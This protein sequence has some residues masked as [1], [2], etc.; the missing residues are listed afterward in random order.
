MNTTKDE[1]SLKQKLI[2]NQSIGQPVAFYSICHF[3]LY[4]FLD[5]AEALLV[6]LVEKSQM[7]KYCKKD[8]VDTPEQVKK[9]GGPSNLPHQKP[10]EQNAL[11]TPRQDAVPQKD[12][13][14]TK[15]KDGQTTGGH[16]SEQETSK[17]THPKKKIVEVEK[18]EIDI[19]KRH[20]SAEKK[21]QSSQKKDKNDLQLK[22]SSQTG[23]KSNQPQKKD[24][25]MTKQEQSSKKVSSIKKKTPSKKEESAK[26]SKQSGKAAVVTPKKNVPPLQ[27]KSDK[28]S[29]TAPKPATDGSK[30]M[31]FRMFNSSINLCDVTHWWI[32][33]PEIFY[34]QNQSC[35]PSDVSQT[36][37]SYCNVALVCFYLPCH[38]CHIYTFSSGF[39]KEATVS[40]Y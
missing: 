39:P 13:K 24:F 40:S 8:V 26:I 16:Q 23:K 22:Q 21:D 30:V 15:K 11:Q 12:M 38:Y 35:L 7:S 29:P 10:N 17:E 3:T 25:Q 36:T 1:G 19:Q 33:S 32:S 5:A 4:F 18:T 6:T 14:S 20:S 9:P 28:K 34:Q 27:T 37:L 31:F 2:G